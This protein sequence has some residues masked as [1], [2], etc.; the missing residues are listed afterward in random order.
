MKKLFNNICISFL[1]LCLFFFFGIIKV[2]AKSSSSNVFEIIVGDEDISFRY[3]IVSIIKMMDST[4]ENEIGILERGGTYELENG[5]TQ[6]EVDTI[7]MKNGDSYTVSQD[8]VFDTDGMQVGIVSNN[9]IVMSDSTEYVFGTSSLQE[10]IIIPVTLKGL[11]T[12]GKNYRWEHSFCYKVIG[13]TELCEV[14]ITGKDQEDGR[15]ILSNQTYSFSYWDG[16]MP[17]YSEALEFEYIRF[18]NRFV[19]IEENCNDVINL[20][21][22]EFRKENNEIDYSYMFSLNVDSYESDGEEYVGYDVYGVLINNG[23]SSSDLGNVPEYKIVNKICVSET[24]CIVKEYDAIQQETLWGTVNYPLTPY[25]GNIRFPYNSEQYKNGEYETISYKTTFVCVN[26]CSNNKRVKNEVVLMDKIFNYYVKSPY[27]DEKNTEITIY[28][29]SSYVKNSQIKITVKED[30][31]GIKEDSLGYY[32]A[33]NNGNSCENVSFFSN[34]FYTFKNGEFFTVGENLNGWYCFAYVASSNVG[35]NYISEYYNFYFDNSAPVLYSDNTYKLDQYYNNVYFDI[36]FRDYSSLGDMYYLW[37][38]HKLEE[39]DNYDYVKN[40]GVKTLVENNFISISSLD[41]VKSDGS[42]YIYILVYDSLGNYELYSVGPINIDITALKVE[43]ISVSSNMSE[44]NNSPSI[45]FSINEENNENQ[46]KCG[47]FNQ[48]NVDS[49]MLNINCKSN[50]A[51]SVPYSLEGEYSLWVYVYDRASNYSLLKLSSNLHIDTK[52]PVVE[53]SILK[54]NDEYHITNEVTINVFDLNEINE[55]T[56]K[57]GWF[58][59]S[60]SNVKEGDLTTS[61]VNGQAIAYPS[62]KYGEYKLYIS[63]SDEFGNVTFLS[64]NKVFK[65]DTDFIR[66]SLVGDKKVTILKGQNYE[67]E[68]AL[69]F[70]GEASSGGRASPITTKG[71]VDVNKKGTYYITYSSGEG[72]FLVSVTRTVVVKD[73]TP[74]IALSLG[75]FIVGGMVISFRLFVRKKENI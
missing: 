37:S 40:N 24:E 49:S 53:Y 12:N 70:K 56:L 1:F 72:D 16:H 51:I 19:C 57:Y 38:N 67:D 14:D 39:D 31:S 55:G 45:M 29:G 4:G 13:G 7:S 47:F 59:K 64:L 61:F 48:D 11:E 2:D 66:I 42:Y 58:L 17:Y 35:T 46:F 8:K 10:K 71:F 28:D 60:K 74:Y 32:I 18:S 9:K 5:T 15:E 62:G 27:V 26:N 63:A 65:V 25:L 22:L 20:E 50:E 21:D 36:D 33:K 54:D 73:N 34:N 3:D 52:S 68:G 69:A 41:D 6:T 43:D 23:N 30:F 75:V 44:Y